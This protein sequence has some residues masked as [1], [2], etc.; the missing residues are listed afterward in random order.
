MELSL[1]TRKEVTR[2]T[3]RSY[4]CSGRKGK[5][6]ILSEFVCSTGYNRAYAAPLLRNYRTEGVRTASTGSLRIVATKT[7]RHAEGRPAIYGR[8]VAAA[9][10]LLLDRTQR[11]AVHPQ[12]RH[13]PNNRPFFGVFLN[14]MVYQHITERNLTVPPSVAV[15]APLAV[16]PRPLHCGQHSRMAHIWQLSDLAGR[17]PFPDIQP[18]QIVPAFEQKSGR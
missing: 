2:V 9:V 11:P 7:Y 15:T 5:A 17:Q 1:R 8:G 12:L 10:E 14:S 6:A 13:Q 18:S 16:K 3:A 4:R